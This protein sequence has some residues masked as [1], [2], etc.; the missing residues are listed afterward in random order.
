ME[1][2]DQPAVN[3]GAGSGVPRAPVKFNLF[4]PAFHAD[5]YE[6]YARLREE[7]PV[8]RTVMGAWVI[9]RYADV[10]TLL[11]DNTFG[12]FDIPTRI[13]RKSQFLEK[14]NMGE[15]RTL[16]Q[17][18]RRWLML[19]DPPDH[20]R[21]R[22]LVNR[23]FT[24][25]AVE[26][27]RPRVQEMVDRLLARVRHTGRMDI[28]NDLAC[29]L[30]VTMIASMLGVPEEAHASVTRWA[31]GLSRVLDP[32]RSLE[33][34]AEMNNV[35]QEFL[36]YFR[37]LFAER[38]RHPREDL[39]SSLIAVTDQGDKL[40]EDEMLSVCMLLFI[41]GEKTTV[42]LI[43]NGTL[44]LLKNRGEMERLRQDPSLI[45]GAIDEMLRYDSPVQ[46]NTR[47][48]K[49]DVTLHGKTIPAG[50]LIYFSLGS[51]NR[52]PTQFPDPDR[53]DITRREKGH[54]AFSGGIH[55]C[56]G[57]ALALI[58]GQVAFSTLVREFPDLE[59]V[60]GEIDWQKEIIFRGPQTLPVTFSP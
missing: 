37:E 23:S 33:Q 43:G 9:T 55:Y 12:V 50:D 56:L 40:T 21:L 30:A 31:D 22:S 39:I 41:A 4:D 11:R 5:P 20:T 25:G 57:A 49:K 6:V 45:R 44:A 7:D 26:S 24:P 51:A 14:K 35:A 2:L 52:D 27:L 46:L 19:C 29:P 3:G 10:K 28:V 47:V 54:L 18:M 53:F 17:A 48:P 34:Y 8:H 60:P 13:E 38:R 32:L 15:L 36:A 1:L 42:N 59:L 58:E 16:A